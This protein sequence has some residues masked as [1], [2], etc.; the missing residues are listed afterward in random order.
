[1]ITHK[2]CLQCWT[3]FEIKKS[4]IDY[5]WRFCSKK[6]NDKYNK[7]EV[8][9]KHKQ[10]K[11]ICPICKKEFLWS[12]RRPHQEC[13]LNKSCIHKRN[14]SFQRKYQKKYIKKKGISHN[15]SVL[16][17]QSLKENKNGWHWE[18]LVDYTLKKLKEHLQSLFINGMSWENHGKWHI[19]HIKPISL[20]NHKKMKDFNSQEFKECWALKNLQPLWA[21]DNIKKRDK[22]IS[23]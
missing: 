20:F 15:I 14:L 3:Y 11:R 10:E 16:M 19:D 5:D 17:Y 23:K 13:C 2:F 8:K 12:T 9:I 7:K 1:M 18:K 4:N 21:I 6:C 22:Y